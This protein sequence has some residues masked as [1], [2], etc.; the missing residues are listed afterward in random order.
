M[1]WLAERLRELGVPEKFERE[2]ALQLQERRLEA[3]IASVEQRIPVWDRLNVLHLTRDEVK[4]NQ[5]RAEHKKVRKDL[6]A[7]DAEI[8]EQLRGLRY[9]S[10]E[11]ELAC[12]IEH[13]MRQARRDLWHS[14]P[15][16]KPLGDSLKSLAARVIEQFAPDLDWDD[17]LRG[18][19]DEGVC[20]QLAREGESHPRQWPAGYPPILS[21]NLR[22]LVARELG[23]LLP[24]LRRQAV[25]VETIARLSQ[26]LTAIT[27]QISVFDRI[28]VIEQS[29]AERREAELKQALEGA[30][31]ELN[32]LSE[33][34]R[35]LC[36]HSLAAYPPLGIYL[37]A[38]EARA[39]LVR[40]RQ[41]YEQTL[42]LQGRIVMAPV[43]NYRHLVLTAL[44]RLHL[45]FR[46]AF[47][48]IKLPRELVTPLPSPTGPLQTFLQQVEKGPAA[49]LRARALAHALMLASVED[50][51]GRTQKQISPVDRLAF[52]KATDPKLRMEL[53][54]RRK[55][56]HEQALAQTEKALVEA[57]REA[58]HS[59]LGFRL[60]DRAQVLVE[61]VSRIRTDESLSAGPRNCP[62]HNQEH[63][64]RLYQALLAV[65]ADYGLNTTYQDFLTQVAAATPLDLTVEPDP[66]AGY[67][68]MTATQLAGMLAFRLQGSDFPAMVTN[69]QELLRT[70]Q[71]LASELEHAI[72]EVTVWDTLNIFT[73]S[74]A[75][76]RRDE[77]AR[78][79][80]LLS[81][82]IARL[83]K[84]V[85]RLLG[86][87]AEC[88]PP[89][90]LYFS[91]PQ[92]DWAIREI[93]AVCTPVRRKSYSGRYYTK[94]RC[95]L[96]G[97]HT[98]ELVAQRWAAALIQT[99]GVLPTYHALME[100]WA[101]SEY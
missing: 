11:L 31:Q 5:L 78:K 60:R 57:T 51:A 73:L 71:A 27:G 70:E 75:E 9:E 28:N 90:A 85:E 10:I 63:C 76:R 6:L 29:P 72:G 46:R 3:E 32:Q 99:Y 41:T 96:K 74:P 95:A 38:L 15:K 52:W 43:L 37:R 33:D 61:G 26:E 19:D 49:R 84:E 20:Q 35:E 23:P 50:E 80:K 18:L 62:V 34:A 82:D 53:L 44:K 16:V 24:N 8:E 42:G 55:A 81:P 65:F 25:L 83:Q 39:L 97:K 89:A 94:Y 22:P 59:L 21:Q 98:A 7:V 100:A 14:P 13:C 86:R 45:A 88:Y 64:S 54:Q 1:E 4:V 2:R 93:K 69:L 68:P 87:A 36:F 12:Q 56:F 17:V 40:L 30:R 77:L 79:R 47:P 58:A 67:P 66:V 101:L 91:L 48:A 92:V